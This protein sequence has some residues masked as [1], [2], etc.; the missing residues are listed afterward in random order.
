MDEPKKD[1][2]IQI[3]PLMIINHQKSKI[4][5]FNPLHFKHFLENSLNFEG[6]LLH[7]IIFHLSND[8]F[9]SNSF[10]HIGYFSNKIDL[11]CNNIQFRKLNLKEEVL[12]VKRNK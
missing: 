4:T 9:K 6:L 8:K 3:I 12:Q 11:Y 2:F 7:E 10:I 1:I 5:C